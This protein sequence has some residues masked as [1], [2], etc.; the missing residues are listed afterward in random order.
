MCRNVTL[1]ESHQA[2]RLLVGLHA[3][4]QTNIRSVR[5]FLDQHTAFVNI[6]CFAMFTMRRCVCLC[7]KEDAIKD[8]KV[9][10]RPT[11]ERRKERSDTRLCSAARPTLRPRDEGRLRVRIGISQ[12][13]KAIHGHTTVS[14]VLD[15][16]VTHLND[17]G[18]SG[19]ACAVAV[20][21]RLCF[22]IGRMPTQRPLRVP[23][24][25]LLMLSQKLVGKALVAWPSPAVLRSP[26]HESFEHT[27]PLPIMAIAA[28]ARSLPF[29]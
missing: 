27:L 14:H 6:L 8:P 9:R 2:L 21:K 19:F 17:V 20:A 25:T 18:K 1:S 5:P 7:T 24:P 15:P 4:T 28:V 29:G 13:M 11:L 23:L 3:R 16:G 12:C 22:R 26:L 10:R